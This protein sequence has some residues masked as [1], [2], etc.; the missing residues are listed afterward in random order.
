MELT[1]AAGEA[2]VTMDALP[3]I[4]TLVTTQSFRILTSKSNQDFPKY[5]GLDAGSAACKKPPSI[6][7]HVDGMDHGGTHRCKQYLH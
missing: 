5:P 2:A 4:I 6:I 7:D 3:H 1:G